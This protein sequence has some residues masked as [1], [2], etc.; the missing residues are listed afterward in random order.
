MGVL[1]Q[2]VTATIVTLV[3]IEIGLQIAAVAA[4]SLL[5]RA[6]DIND[7][8]TITILCVGDSHTYG[9]PLPEA[10]A[11]PAHSYSACSTN[12]FPSGASR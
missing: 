12:G 5:S 11:Y 7:S 10:D 6:G 4:P 1:R 3:V 9:A 2:M 8:S